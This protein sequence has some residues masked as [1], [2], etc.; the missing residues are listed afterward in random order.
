MY[1]AVR[2][3]CLI[4]ATFMA[5]TGLTQRTISVQSNASAAGANEK[6]DLPDPR[7]VEQNAVAAR[8]AIRFGRLEISV[9]SKNAKRETALAVHFEF[10]YRTSRKLRI[11]TTRKNPRIHSGGRP[12]TV[13][14]GDSIERLVIDGERY[15]YYSP[16]VLS[17]A[18]TPDREGAAEIG[19][20]SEQPS[21]ELLIMNPLLLGMIPDGTGVLFQETIEGF[22]TAPGRRDFTI[23][24][25]TLNNARCYQVDCITGNGL[26]VREWIAPERGYSLLKVHGRRIVEESHKVFEI[27]WNCRVKHY[28]KQQVWFPE[29]ITNRVTE[30]GMPYESEQ[31]VITNA[32]FSMPPD[33][34]TFELKSLDIRPGAGISE[35]PPHGKYGRRWNGKE[36]EEIVP[37]KPAVR[38]PLLVQPK[39]HGRIWLFVSCG[40]AGLALLC[41]LLARRRAATRTASPTEPA[42]DNPENP[43]APPP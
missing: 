31:I 34:A 6:A 3:A 18:G 29:E 12:A 10:D 37:P 23:E 15:L 5:L 35:D 27:D 21:M 36:L 28:P 7:D 1:N 13:K 25:A 19:T 4:C 8:R 30:D 42:G 11:D 22:L 38:K 2:A 43:R 24:S 26:E 16:D 40:C 14:G 41:A 32:D 39:N 20:L 33:P 9:S 17:V